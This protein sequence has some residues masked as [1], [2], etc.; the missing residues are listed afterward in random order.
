MEKERE[1][2]CLTIAIDCKRCVLCNN[3][4]VADLAVLWRTILIPGLHLKDAVVDLAL[5][6]RSVELRFPEHGGELIYIIHLDMHHRPATEPESGT[7][8]QSG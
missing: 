1:R 5:S 3:L 7:K 8:K 2:L 4:I 6:H